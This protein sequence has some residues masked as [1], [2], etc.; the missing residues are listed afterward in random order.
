ML[1]NN[2]KAGIRLAVVCILLAAVLA[3]CGGKNKE[4]PSDTENTGSGAGG[5]TNTTVAV[6][7]DAAGESAEGQVSEEQLN[8]FV[9]VSKFFNPMYM[10][11]EADPMFRE[12]MLKQL[13][14]Y[15]ILGNRLQ[16][17]ALE[18]ASAKASEEYDMFIQMFTE[19]EG[20]EEELDN[21][22]KELNIAR[23]DIK[24]YIEMY[25]LASEY[26]D[27]TV[28]DAAV[29][30]SYDQKLVDNPNEFTIATVSHILFKTLADTA[31]EEPKYTEEEAL[32]K[33]NEV[34]SEIIGGADFAEMAME[35]S[36]DTGSAVNGG[37][38]ENV[39]V[40]GF[41]ENFKKATIELPLHEVSEPVGTEYGYHLIRVEDRKEQTFD[42][43]KEAVRNEL[44]SEKFADFMDKELDDLISSISLPEAQQS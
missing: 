39:N 29:K 23:D 2:W 42:E 43:V 13:I 22:L 12:Q 30:D 19:G 27:S 16:G 1:R 34:R 35:W 11:Y 44:M 15:R 9:N 20:A 28:E 14:A 6:Y 8:S 32:A 38:M 36:D 26:L 5:G 10:Y 37:K 18:E 17:T 21:A 4:E 3:A 24:T 7:K 31:E 40:N 41:V 33:A 25:M